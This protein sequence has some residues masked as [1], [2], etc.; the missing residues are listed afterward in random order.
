MK[1]ER[2]GGRGGGGRNRHGGEPGEEERGQRGAPKSGCQRADWLWSETG[3]PLPSPIPK[4]QGWAGTPPL[5]LPPSESCSR[6]GPGG[7]EPASS[8]Q[9]QPLP[10]ADQRFISGWEWVTPGCLHWYQIGASDVR[11]HV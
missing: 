8:T 3:D 11:K 7:K 4:D 1:K 9:T 5:H 10:L 6:S 2:V